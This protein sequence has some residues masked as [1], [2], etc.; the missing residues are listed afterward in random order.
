[1]VMYTVRKIIMV[2]EKHVSKT[3]YVLPKKKKK[4]VGVLYT[5]L[6]VFNKL[7]ILLSIAGREWSPLV[8][9]WLS[10]TASAGDL[11]S[12]ASRQ[13]RAAARAAPRAWG[14]RAASRG[15]AGS[16]RPLS[17]PRLP[18]PGPRRLLAVTPPHTHT[19]GEQLLRIPAAA[20]RPRDFIPTDCRNCLS[21]LPSWFF[22][23]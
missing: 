1:M 6:H 21:V 10:Q 11:K 19:P 17:S 7:E 13:L 23:F 3:L 5:F 18:Q 12:T 4:S 14:R 15:G 16:A 2:W 22:S 20:G 9:V 8:V